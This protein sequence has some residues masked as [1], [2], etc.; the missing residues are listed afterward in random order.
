M[1]ERTHRSAGSYLLHV[2]PLTDSS[3]CVSL[4]QCAFVVDFDVC[5]CPTFGTKGQWALLKRGT[6]SNLLLSLGFKTSANIS[7]LFLSF[8]I[9]HC[10][11]Y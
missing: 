1:R 5:V 2:L 7:D 4:F 11:Y 9:D 6:R 10:N 8:H 3:D